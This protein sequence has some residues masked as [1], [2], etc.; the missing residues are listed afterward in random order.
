MRIA[1]LVSEFPL[2]SETF[3]VNQVIG[4]L[5]AGHTVDIYA[6]HGQPPGRGTKMHADVLTYQL[7]RRAYYPPKCP[8]QHRWR[9]LKGLALLASRLH[10]APRLAFSWL[11]DAVRGE[12]FRGWRLLYQAIPTLGRGPYDII[13]AQFGTTALA[14]LQLRD[15]GALQGRLVTT[16]RGYDISQFVRARGPD[17]YGDLFRRGD[18]FLTNCDFFYRR[19][20]RLG[21]P[22]ARTL[23]HRSGIDCTRFAMAP[24]KRS[25]RRSLRLTSTGRL[26]EKKGF[27]YAIRAVAR[28][29]RSYPDLRYSIIGD[30]P[31][32]NRLE[33]LI[34]ELRL[35]AHVRLL[36]Q[37]S[38]HEILDILRRSDVFIAPSITAADGNQDAPV[39]TLKEAMA[40]GVPVIATAHGGIPELVEHGRTGLLVPEKSVVEL[41]DTLARLLA[42][43]GRGKA[44]VAAARAR[45][46][47]EYDLSVLNTRLLGIYADLVTGVLQAPPAPGCER[48]GRA[49]AV[50]AAWT[51]E[52]T[53]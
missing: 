34:R 11:A 15:L 39:N 5:D 46:E 14:G 40:I 44:M 13:H 36:G 31:L 23:V 49:P 32:R 41:A 47:H 8:R 53:S 2:L 3:I 17:V 6:L 27:E 10:R 21:A 38:Q 12:R 51:V 26:V 33:A 1:Y 19:L 7:M 24:R 45:I 42:E 30:G 37:R 48:A 52:D 50:A 25:A 29:H 28:L 35:E 16:F 22:A 4:L 9:A 43:R 18:C 20:L